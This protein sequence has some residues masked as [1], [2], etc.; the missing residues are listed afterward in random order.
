MGGIKRWWEIGYGQFEDCR[1][2]IWYGIGEAF[3]EI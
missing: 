1:G 2:F 3:L